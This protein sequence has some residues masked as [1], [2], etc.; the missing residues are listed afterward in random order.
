MYD[1]WQVGD[2]CL[3]AAVLIMSP[4]S[5]HNNKNGEN[6]DFGL[7]FYSFVPGQF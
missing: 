6:C 4:H 1:S 5:H 3:H 2:D 7:Y